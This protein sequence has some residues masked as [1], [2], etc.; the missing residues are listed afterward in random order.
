M[1]SLPLTPSHSPQGSLHSD[2]SQPRDFNNTD[3]RIRRLDGH[4]AEL[5]DLMGGDDSGLDNDSTEKQDTNSGQAE[6]P[7]Y[8]HGQIGVYK[9]FPR[10][11]QASRPIVSDNWRA[12]ASFAGKPQT[13]T[14]TSDGNKSSMATPIPTS[15]ST[16]QQDHPRS[17]ATALFS[18][19]RS[20]LTAPIDQSTAGF[21]FHSLALTNLKAPQA[22]SGPISGTQVSPD[23]TSP[24]TPVSLTASVSTPISGR[25]AFGL[26][27]GHVHHTSS[28][29]VGTAASSGYQ[30]QTQTQTQTQPTTHTNTQPVTV[31]VTITPDTLGYCFVRPDGTRTRLVPVDML[32]FALEGMPKREGESQRE[33]LVELPVPGGVGEDE[34]SSNWQV[35]SAVVSCFLSLSSF[36]SFSVSCFLSPVNGG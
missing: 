3:H 18:P 5:A 14:Q 4:C 20:P 29:S 10:F 36:F 12:A 2:S 35:L 25:A 34:R 13:Q 7:P 32:P 30:V 23:P 17:T 24:P 11:D 6:H 15:T 16:F 22:T 9:P 31:T 21:G 1:A 19:T 27:S 8:R 26:E 28:S 33:R